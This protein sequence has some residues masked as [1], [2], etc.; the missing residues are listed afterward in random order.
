MSSPPQVRSVNS[1]TPH[2]TL[3]EAVMSNTTKMKVVILLK[4]GRS[5]VA[6]YK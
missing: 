5:L 1:W 3:D 4:M 2:T 6:V